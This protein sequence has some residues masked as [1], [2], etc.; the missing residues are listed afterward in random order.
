MGELG[1]NTNLSQ[2]WSGSAVDSY[3]FYDSRYL[4]ILAI[5]YRFSNFLSCQKSAQ[6]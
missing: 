3:G 5:L 6:S 2:D 4:I 1:C